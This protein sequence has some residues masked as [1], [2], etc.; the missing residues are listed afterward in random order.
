M[1]SVPAGW[2][3]VRLMVLPVVFQEAVFALEAAFGGGE[4]AQDEVVVLD[5][6]RLPGGDG[7]RAVAEHMEVVFA[8]HAEAVPFGL[9]GF[10]DEGVEK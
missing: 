7:G 6:V 2:R 1:V 4:I 8:L 3:G 10:E 9:G 5:F